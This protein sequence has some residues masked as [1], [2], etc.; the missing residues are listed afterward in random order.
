M[1]SMP[2][3]RYA[4]VAV[5]SIAAALSLA[6][7]KKEAV[8]AKDEPVESVAK[9]V[10]AAKMNPRPGR[11]E[12]NITLN[13]IDMPGLPPQAREAMRKQMS[14]I[15]AVATCL[16]PEQ[17][18]KP[19]GGFFQPG[20]KDCKYDRFVMADGR[21]DAAMTC[22]QSGAAQT[23]TMAGAYSETQYDLQVTSKGEMQ[24]GMPMTMDVA[25]SARRTGECTG[26]E[27]K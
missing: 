7:C 27:D 25:I 11:W 16:T 12:A 19:E 17:A 23:M 2:T 22:G 20:A 26:A 3:V 24:P 6:A 18:E 15:K 9:K 4:A 13:R 8:V 14:T 1:K 5:L 10:A 21:V